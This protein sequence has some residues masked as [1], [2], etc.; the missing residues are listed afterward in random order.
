MNFVLGLQRTQRRHDSIFVVVEFFLKMTH[1]IPCKKTSDD[2]HVAELFFREVVTLHGLTKNIVLDR[3]TQFFVLKSSM[4]G[5]L[6]KEKH[7]I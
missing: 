2:V 7:I 3:D 5:N 6:I 1:F 4:R